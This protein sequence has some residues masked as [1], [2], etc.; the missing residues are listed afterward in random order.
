MQVTVALSDTFPGNGFHLMFMPDIVQLNINRQSCIMV[1][2]HDSCIHA[3]W[4]P[5]N[6]ANDLRDKYSAS[7]L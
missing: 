7:H 5:G 4:I 1:H 3:Q 6:D 2:V